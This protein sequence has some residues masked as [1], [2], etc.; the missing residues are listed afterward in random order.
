MQDKYAIRKQ[1][2]KIISGIDQSATAIL[3]GSRARGNTSPDSDWDILI[4]INKPKVL[5]KDEQVFRHSLY[6]LELKIG[7]PISTFVYSLKDWNDK[8][9]I[10]PLY[11]NIQREGL[12]I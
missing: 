9:S 11:K 3:Y 1:I 5:L 2:K 12:V 4:L 8:L 10:T 7:Q 6:E